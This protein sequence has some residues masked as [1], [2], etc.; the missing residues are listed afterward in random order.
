MKKGWNYLKKYISQFT[1]SYYEIRGIENDKLIKPLILSA[2]NCVTIHIV[3]GGIINILYH[4]F[5]SPSANVTITA[6]LGLI[7]LFISCLYGKKW[8]GRKIEEG[9][10]LIST[11]IYFGIN[12]FI[13]IFIML[14]FIKTKEMNEIDVAMGLVLCYYWIVH[15]FNLIP[16]RI[17][18]KIYLYLF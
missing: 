16:G 3:S 8:I 18:I 11:N 6:F 4:I 2:Y 10:T 7:P 1:T 9:K 15:S 12:L 5:F 14:L 17:A 13:S